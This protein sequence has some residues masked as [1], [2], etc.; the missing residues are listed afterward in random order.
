VQV[1]ISEELKSGSRFQLQIS[2][3]Y[4]LSIYLNDEVDYSLGAYPIEGAYVSVVGWRK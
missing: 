4:S 1:D 2:S 3:P